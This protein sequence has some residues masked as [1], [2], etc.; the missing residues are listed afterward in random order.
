MI[1]QK[2]P[3]LD[4][5]YDFDSMSSERKKVFIEHIFLGERIFLN[6]LF[7]G[8]M[9]EFFLD[10]FEK[11]QREKQD[12]IINGLKR[13]MNFHEFK[14]YFASFFYFRKWTTLC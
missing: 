13:K 6:T 2:E 9:I 14:T 11:V 4:L 12:D 5:L 1:A 3:D 10:M 8:I 7:S